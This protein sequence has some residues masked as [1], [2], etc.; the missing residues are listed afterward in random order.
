MPDTCYMLGSI[1]QMVSGY[2]KEDSREISPIF[3]VTDI[4]TMIFLMV[5]FS[6]H[7]NALLVGLYPVLVAP[8]K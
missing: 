7:T 6:R 1:A 5:F 3:Q 4:S 2:Q 8:I